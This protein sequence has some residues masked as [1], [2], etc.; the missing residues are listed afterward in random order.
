MVSIVQ[1]ILVMEDTSRQQN[2]NVYWTVVC[3]GEVQGVTGGEVIGKRSLERYGNVLGVVE[4]WEEGRVVPLNGFIKGKDSGGGEGDALQVLQESFDDYR[5]SSTVKKLSSRFEPG[6]C[7]PSQRDRSPPRHSSFSTTRM[8]PGSHAPCSLPST[9][10]G[11]ATR[12]P[13]N[14][15]QYFK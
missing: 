2:Q 6:I 12:H 4:G 8:L 1:V 11:N 13:L 10:L 5:P 3:Y 7:N 9:Y 15:N 14:A